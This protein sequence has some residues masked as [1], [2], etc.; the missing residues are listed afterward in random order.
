MTQQQVRM[1]AETKPANCV[2][3]WD[4]TVAAYL[5]DNAF[6]QDQIGIVLG[7][8]AEHRQRADLQGFQRGFNAASRQVPS[9]TRTDG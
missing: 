5:R 1:Q 7:L 2:T 9:R 3:D 4:K 6:S 8:L